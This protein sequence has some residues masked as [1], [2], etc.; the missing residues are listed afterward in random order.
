MTAPAMARSRHP[1]LAAWLAWQEQAHARPIDLGLDRVAQV[2]DRLQLRPAGVPVITVGGTNGKGSTVAMLEAIYQAA[3]YRVGCYTSPHLIHYNERIRIDGLPVPDSPICEAFEAI[4]RARGEISLSYFEFGTLAALWLFH[5]ER[6]DVM[7]LEVGLGGRLDAVN[8]LDADVAVVTAVGIDH[9]AF[10][11]DDRESIG[12]EKAGIFRPGRVAV[13]GDAD[14]PGRLLAHGARIGSRLLLA[15]R[16]FAPLTGLR[17]DTWQYRGAGLVLEGLPAP[18][19][20]GGVQYRNAASAI[21]AVLSLRERLPV[22]QEAVGQGL[23]AAR[24]P[25]RFQLLQEAPALWVDVAHNPQGAESL[26][27]NLLGV[28]CR[29]RT[30]AVMGVMADKD[31]HGIV[32]PLLDVMRGW[33]VAAPRTERAL[34]ASQLATCL[35]TLT[36][37]PVQSHGSVIQACQAALAEAGPEDRVIVFGSFYTVAEVLQGDF[38]GPPR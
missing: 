1:T 23:T 26:A 4:D 31:V 21:T 18:A 36:Q 22:T 9:Q 15:G 29:G 19:L 37:Q 11:G 28:P 32:Q 17:M 2:A 3:G 7:V 6:V 20:S 25:G 12:F 8:I 34:G 33:H 13:C 16:D 10:L 27:M 14:P 5:R 24:L 35:A 30:L 38:S